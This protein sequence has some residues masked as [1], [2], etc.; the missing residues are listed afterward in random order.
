MTQTEI[1]YLNHHISQGIGNLGFVLT[2]P[3][4]QEQNVTVKETNICHNYV[5]VQFYPVDFSHH[6]ITSKK[7]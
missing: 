4:Y 7:N 6:H 5:S 3:K 2:Y 1:F